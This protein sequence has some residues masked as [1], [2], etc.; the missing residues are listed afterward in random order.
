MEEIL[1]KQ[2]IPTGTGLNRPDVKHYDDTIMDVEIPFFHITKCDNFMKID[3]DLNNGVDY[4]TVGSSLSS[5]IEVPDKSLPNL[6]HDI[7]FSHLADSTDTQFSTQFGVRSDSYDH[8]SPDVIIKTAA[9]SYFVVEFTTNRGGEKGALQAC[10]DK[11][12]KYHI[13]CENR[14][15]DCVVSLFVIAV[16]TRGV[17]TNLDIGEEDCNELVFRFRL[18]V[19]IM[20]EAKKYY[21]ELSGD[22]SELSKHEREILG[23]VSSIQMNWEKTTGAFPYFKESVFEKFLTTPADEEY[24]SNVISEELKVCQEEMIKSGFI[25][26]SSGI[27]EKLDKNLEECVVEV[28]KYL[29]KFSNTEYRGTLESKST[30]QIPPWLMSEF[31]D[32]KSVSCLGEFEVSGEH[33][34]CKIW[35]AVTISAALGQIDRA[36]DSPEQ[37]LEKALNGSIDKSDERSRYH[38][39]K[40]NLGS[41][42]VMYGA[43]LGVEGKTHRNN[44]QVEESRKRSKLCFSIEHDVSNLEEFIN[45]H[46]LALFEEDEDLFN[47]FDVDT[48]LRIAAQKIHQPDLINNCDGNEF[49]ENHRKFLSSR[50]GSWCQMVSL[51]GA[52]LS[53]SVKQHVGAGQFVIKRLLNSPLFLLIKPTS[54]VSHIFVSF[55]LVKNNH[56]GNLWDDGV[57]KHYIDAGDLLITD[58]I[59][60]KLSKLTNLCKCFPLV[61]SSVCFWTEV[62]GFEPWNAVSNLSK[63]RSGSSKEATSMIKLTLLTLME[64]KAVTEEIQTIQRYIVM[65]GFVSSPEMPKPHKMIPKLP[66][67]LRSELQ[68]YLL[69]RCLRTMETISRKPFRLQKKQGQISWS[70]LFNPLT[71]NVLRDLQPLISICYNGYFKNKEEETEP[72]ALSR[73]YKKIIELEHL[74]PESDEFLGEGDPVNPRMHEFSRSFLKKCTDHGKTVLR[75]VYGHNFIQQ[76]DTQIIREIS[77]ITLERLAT[78]KASSNFDE[79]WYNYNECSKKDYHRE[80]A[81]VKMSDFAATGKTLAIEVFDESMKLIEDRGNMHICLFKKQQHGGDREIYVL[82]REERIVQSIVEAIARSIGRFFPS[83]T[84]CN[85]ANKTKIPESH[86]IRARKHCR[87]PVWTCSTSDDARKWNQGHFVTKF[88]LMLCEFTMPKWWPIIIRG[89]SMFTN[90][91]MMMNMR[92]IDILSRHQELHVADEFSQQIFKAYHGEVEVPWMTSGGTYLKTKTGMMQ[93]ILHFTSSLLHTLHQEFVRSLTFKIF[94]SKVHPEMSQSIVVDM[95]QGS[96]DSSMMISYPC[97]DESVLMKCKI[98]SAICFRMKKRLGIYLA[99]YP[100]EKSTANTDFVMEYNSE[101]FFHSQHVRPTVRWVAACC[102][103]PE[104]ET[105][106]A[107]QEEASNLMTSISEGGGSFSL[108]ACI[109]QAQ[110]TLHYMLMGMGVSSLFEEYKKAILK[111]KDPGLGFFLL[112]NPYCAGLGGFRF[113]LYK[114]I[115]T[116][117]LKGLYS[118]FMKKVRQEGELSGNV[119]PES[120]SVSPGG[121]IVLSSALR[122]GSKQKFYKLRDKLKIPEDWIDQIN[123]NPSVLYRAPKSGEEVILR[124]AEKVHSPGVVSSL[125]TGN[126]VAKVIA[127]SVYFL[128]AAIFQDSGKQEYSILDQSKYSLLQKLHKFEGINLK[129]AISDEDLLFLFPNIEDLQSLDSLVYNRGAIEIVRRK[130]SRE[131]TQT[132]VT[133]FE[134]NR[135][136]RTPAEYLISD[137]WFGTQ[138]SKIGRTAFEQEWDKITSIIPWLGETPEETLSLSPLDNHI[139]IRNFFSRMD[140]K[141]RVVRVTGAPVKKRSGVSKISMVIRDNFS[142]L[143][144]I[145]DIEDITGASRTTAAEMLKH[146]LFCALQGPYTQEMKLQLVTKL[147]SISNPIGIK[148]SDGKS[149]SNILAIFQNYIYGDRQIARQIED[150]GAGTIG[151][152][153]IP[154]KPKKIEGSVYYYGPGVWRGIMDGKQVQIELDN[155]IGNPPSITAVTMEESA[156]P[157]MICRSIKT[158]AEDMGAKN[159]IDMSKKYSKECKYWMFDFKTYSADKAYGVPVYLSSKRM[160]DFRQVK[161][162][163]ID[164]KVRKST[165]NLFIKNEGRDVHILSYTASDSDLSPAVLKTSDK[166]KDE[167]MELFPREPSRSWASCSP[168]PYFAVHKILRVTTGEVNVTSLDKDRLSEIMKLCCES[169][170]RSRVGTIFSPIPM[171]SE[172][173][174]HVDVEDLID[175]VLTDLKSNNFNEIVKSLENDL[176][177]EYEL[178]E[179]DYSD[180]DLFGPAHYKELSDLTTISHPLMDDFVEFCISS[181]GRKEIRRVLEQGRC[182]NKDLKLAQDLFSA[183]RRNPDGIIVDD[184][185]THIDQEFE[186]DMIG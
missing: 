55:A 87:G 120:C 113:N 7:V 68:V 54:S 160:V 94:N 73:L 158:W 47:P 3:L 56:M 36:D 16:H 127:S 181:L 121:A 131:N 26:G 96:D 95:M 45:K 17:W 139:Q 108:S 107:R 133:V 15:I 34:M 114:A 51:I 42:E 24:L 177:E 46:E 140:Q 5:V 116:T 153:I 118:Y 142:K 60:Y 173:R 148:D 154:Q 28:A 69:N 159:N 119:I 76:I 71:G 67:V 101:F 25:G 172:G 128:S 20:E 110:C 151:G 23:V 137:K 141:P 98:A 145:K 57:F 150:A 66:T 89:C 111:W 102:N 74:C 70:G 49:L 27:D 155:A 164:I 63:D 90:K 72:S 91:Y 11:F 80:K 138:K 123:N 48:D 117:N 39:L 115:T 52:E 79:K 126:A 179:F 82:G 40:L 146:F 32:G 176:K 166:I 92:Y 6:I 132:R 183:L 130:Q 18:A 33:P 29:S 41:E 35:R 86:G 168:I 105:L 88:A 85:P 165:I 65:E 156:E 124:I 167:M 93:G 78:L 31:S 14:A 22:D 186:D 100:S 180:I 104:V 174:Q 143:G 135:N 163:E 10:K 99:I 64:D 19:A 162:S 38:R 152:F 77:S 169:S 81:I 84:L 4:S 53:A 171:L 112:D 50:L 44:I 1:K 97:S 184:Y 157:W 129:N 2:S 147:L 9:G 62:F 37:E 13:P 182:K 59:S 61:E 21:P 175:I 12:S 149:R 109:Q 106:V 122:W 30:I 161:D 134:G 125:S 144:Y 75:K 170:L 185:N 83:D 43:C 58:F 178:E 136:L 8:L 103:L